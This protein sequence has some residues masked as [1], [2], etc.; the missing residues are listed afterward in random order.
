MKTESV[1]RFLTVD[2]MTQAPA[3]VAHSARNVE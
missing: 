1:Q 2:A 3:A